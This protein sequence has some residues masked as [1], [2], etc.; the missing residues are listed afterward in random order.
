MVIL[1]GAMKMCQRADN[2]VLP[3]GRGGFTLTEVL[4]VVAIIGLLAA[5]LVGVT[6]YVQTQSSIALTEQ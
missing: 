4:I 5:G 6:S 2:R 1:S 3:G